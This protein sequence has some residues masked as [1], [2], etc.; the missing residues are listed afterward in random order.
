MIMVLGLLISVGLLALA[1]N[2]LSVS[3][4]IKVFGG[5][6]IWPWLPLAVASYLGGHLVRGWRCR[7]LVSNDADLPLVTASNIVVVGYAVNNILPARMGEL[8]RAGMLAERSGISIMQSLTVTFVERVLDGLTILFLLG[9]SILFVDVAYWIHTTLMIA[10]AIFATSLMLILIAVFR[11]YAIIQLFTKLSRRFSPKFQDPLLRLII[12]F[13]AGISYLRKPKQFLMVSQL[14]LLVWALEAG[15]FWFLFPVLGLEMNYWWALL[16]M[17]VTNLGILLPSSPG[18]IGPF[19]YFCMQT[20]IMFGVAKATA[21]TYALVTHATFY[22]PI[23]IWGLSII[24]LYGIQLSRTIAQARKARIDEGSENT[25]GFQEKVVGA[26]NR[27][28][29]PIEATLFIRAICEALLP[30][31]LGRELVG[32]RR[33]MLDEVTEFVQ[34]QLNSLP[35]RLRFL[36]AFGMF[37]FKLYVALFYFSTFCKLPLKKRIHI[38]EFWAYGW[39]TPMRQLFRPITSSLFLIFFEQDELKEQLEL[40]A[41]QDGVLEGGR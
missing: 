41:E 27:S 38:V 5:L 7:L 33:K 23:T 35:V 18:F 2:S 17:S 13:V 10:V 11:P 15:M 39:I 24:F 8:A 16:A 21:M 32:D 25:E 26:I 28:R 37:G 4:L 9:L 36:F 40:A 34:G 31:V 1:M 19:H 22:I 12:Q 29:R 3:D 30:D 6:N 20:L 14:S